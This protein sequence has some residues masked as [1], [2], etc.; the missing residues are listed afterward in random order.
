M[1]SIPPLLASYALSVAKPCLLAL[2]L[3]LAP[4]IAGEAFDHGGGGG[5]GR[6]CGDRGGLAAGEAE[7][8]QLLE[9]LL[10]VPR[11]FRPQL[12]R[13]GVRVRACEF[14]EGG[15]IRC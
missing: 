6:W 13:A 4:S 5:D 14:A 2:S 10:L 1:I 11:P 12:E 15:A 9:E 7:A 8:V 3:A